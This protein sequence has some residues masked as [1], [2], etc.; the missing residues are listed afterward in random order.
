M[1]II[2][3][4][5]FPV[6]FTV[7]HAFDGGIYVGMDDTAKI[8]YYNWC[9]GLDQCYSNIC[10]GLDTVNNCNGAKTKY[11]AFNP[12]HPF[13]RSHCYVNGL[14]VPVNVT[15]GIM[16]GQNNYLYNSSKVCH[17]VGEC[18]SLVCRMWVDWSERV[19]YY[20]VVIT[21]LCH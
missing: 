21:G 17:T 3:A 12:Y 9:N 2:S 13:N 4:F 11:I 8:C 6:I 20:L 14:D 16:V 19:K 1:F 15:V 10:R 7:C 5:I 18:A